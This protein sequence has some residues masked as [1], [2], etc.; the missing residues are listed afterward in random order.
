M[1]SLIPDVTVTLSIRCAERSEA[2]LL[3]DEIT[4]FCFLIDIEPQH[5]IPMGQ[6]HSAE[7]MQ[8]ER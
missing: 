8:W 3:E 1:Q 6:L 4:I 5:R 2:I 7:R